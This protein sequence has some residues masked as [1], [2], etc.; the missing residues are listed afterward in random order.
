M[1][2]IRLSRRSQ[3]RNSFD[4]TWHDSILILGKRN[5]IGYLLGVGRQQTR[6]GRREHSRERKVSIS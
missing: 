4:Y 6:K 1:S 2:D 3:A 5:Q